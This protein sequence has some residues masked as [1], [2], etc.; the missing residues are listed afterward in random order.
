MMD[1]KP[2]IVVSG[3]PRSG[4]S[5]MMKILAA[6]GVEIL[7]DQIREADDNNP[8]GYFELEVVKKL[9]DGRYDWIGEAEGKAVKVIATLITHLPNKFN[10][11]IVFMNRDLNEVLASQ[12]KM[13]GRLGKEDDKVSDQTMARVFE[14]HLAGIKKWIASQKNMEVLYVSYNDILADPEEPINLVAE[15]LDMGLDVE[16]MEQVVNVNLYRERK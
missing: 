8:E 3:L 10:Y 5:M 15:F 16:E 11:K 4:T 7:T 14:N 9:K 13:L 1:N 6:G 2:V 12:K